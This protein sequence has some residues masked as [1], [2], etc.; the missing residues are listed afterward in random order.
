MGITSAS[1]LKLGL[2]NTVIEEPL[3]GAHRDPELAANRLKSALLQALEE[4]LL[5][6]PEE[7]VSRR[8]ARFAAIGEYIDR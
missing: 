3:G 1:L 2:V 7:L 4:P 6:K 5:L 8:R